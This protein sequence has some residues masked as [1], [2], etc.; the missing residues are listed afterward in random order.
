MIGDDI[1]VTVLFVDGQNVKIGI[2][3]PRNVPVDREEVAKKKE[4][5]T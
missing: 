3:A 4:K 2:D 1:I 5:L